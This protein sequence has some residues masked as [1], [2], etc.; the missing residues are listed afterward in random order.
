MPPPSLTVFSGD[1]LTWQTWKSAFETVIGK[2]AI[3]SSE[4]IL[5]LLQYLSGTPRKV[6]EGY[7]FVS[8]PDAYETAKKVLEKR[9][10]YPSVVSQAF[11]SKLE[12]WQKIPPR[13]GH[14]LREFADFL[15]TC[16]LAMQSVEDVET[17]NKEN[18]NKKL[19]RILPSWAHPKWGT[20]V[21]DSQTKY[22][23]TKFHPFSAFVDFVTEIAEVQCLPVLAGG[24]ANNQ[25]VRKHRG[26]PGHRRNY[27]GST[28]ATSVRE[29]P[30]TSKR[31]HV[32]P[33]GVRDCTNW[34]SV[35]NF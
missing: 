28:L 21:H 26:S 33:C 13:D 12:N 6:V 35:K 2:R 10:G 16:K 14:A 22:G 27:K 29:H 7:Q 3:N 11:R 8:T 23:D 31:N 25:E 18:D 20:K 9:F 32:N 15:R 24:E 19:I 5:Y 34:I 30:G 17:L 4:K 1:P